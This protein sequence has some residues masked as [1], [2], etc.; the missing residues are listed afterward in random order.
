[1]E[2]RGQ[3]RGP[4]DD[5]SDHIDT[6]QYPMQLPMARAQRRN[7]LQR[8]DQQRDRCH[9]HV[10]ECPERKLPGDAADAAISQ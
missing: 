7:E 2:R 5:A 9:Q 4:G 3:S 6:A 8:P 10:R 1:M